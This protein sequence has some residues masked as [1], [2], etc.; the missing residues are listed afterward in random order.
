MVFIQFALALAAMATSAA[1]CAA[2]PRATSSAP[3]ESR[4]GIVFLAHGIWPD[5][6]W[7]TET[8]RA[9]RAARIEVVPVEYTSFI[10]GYIAGSGTDEPAERIAAFVA[11]LEREHARTGCR[12]P[13]RYHAIAYSAGTVVAL[14]AA[15]RGVR[16]ETAH[17]GGSPI[18]AWSSSLA[19][20]VRAK[21][22]GLV[23]NYWSPLDG[24]TGWGFGMGQ[25][26]YHGEED[27]EALP[28]ENVLCAYQHLA[29]PFDEELAGAIA[30]DLDAAARAAPPHTCFREPAFA[31]WYRRE[32]DRLAA[33]DAIDDATAEC[34]K[35]VAS[36]P[37][38]TSSA[39]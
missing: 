12:A 37:V 22:I 19:D 27:G 13:L 6:A 26:G 16:L 32:T 9:L 29:P 17:F 31:R 10:A 14:K 24:V 38:S 39:P 36:A 25:F 23:K 4:P 21:R 5:G 34:D 33:G 18:P 3:L 8:E 2:P 28:V 20:A 35:S 30:R 7:C 11:A 15:W 1:G